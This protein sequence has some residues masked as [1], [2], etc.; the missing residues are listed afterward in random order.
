MSS[1]RSS[2]PIWLGD[3]S[4][5]W[6]HIRLHV[7]ALH[8]ERLSGTGVVLA[9]P[10]PAKAFTLAV[11]QGL[12][13][14]AELQTGDARPAAETLAGYV[15]CD[16]RTVRRCLRVLE[17]VGYIEIVP[18]PG[19]ANVYRLLPPPPL[20]P[21]AQSGVDHAGADSPPG[22]SGSTVRTGADSQS[23]EQEPLNEN[24]ERE[25]PTSASAS[26]AR[27]VDEAEA[28]ADSSLDRRGGQLLAE[29]ARLMHD[30]LVARLYQPEDAGGR[31]RLG[32]RLAAL[33]R[34]GWPTV[35]LV[36]EVAGGVNEAPGRSIVAVL[37]TRA[38]RL[39]PSPFIA[40]RT[41]S[42]G[43]T[44]TQGGS[45]APVDTLETARQ[46]GGN[47]ADAGLP[48]DLVYAELEHLYGAPDAEW[49]D[50]LVAALQGASL[51]DEH[52]Q[53]TDE[54]RHAWGAA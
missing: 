5:G 25:E 22:G 21:G 47:L 11:Y 37:L 18:R 2:R 8:D 14:H 40:R 33:E 7:Q 28:E 27:A 4:R 54:L 48:A 13:A 30:E 17:A 51:L 20:T 50:E 42:G 53:P 6:D 34:S 36:V 12:A 46:H 49:S 9:E 1:E 38:R 35:D 52:R 39:D 3:D 29:L 41:D 10:A 15:G 16:E 26:P 45:F 24:Q 32:R 31:R 43:I 19:L 23:D 44:L